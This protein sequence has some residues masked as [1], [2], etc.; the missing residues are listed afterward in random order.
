MRGMAPHYVLT[1]EVLHGLGI[2]ADAGPAGSRS[3]VP[4]RGSVDVT[5]T[6]IPAPQ[7]AGEFADPLHGHYPSV[8]P[9]AARPLYLANSGKELWVRTLAGG[10]AV[11][12]GYNA[13]VAPAPAVAAKDRAAR[14]RDRELVAS[15]STSA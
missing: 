12:V 6:P 8:L 9:S 5:L 10:R 7:Y 3:S 4:A 13:V 15:S 1:A 2:T 14:A 11:Y